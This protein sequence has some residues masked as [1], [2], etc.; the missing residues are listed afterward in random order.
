[1][2]S[3][4]RKSFVAVSWI[5]PTNTVPVAVY[6]VWLVDQWG[7]M[8][9][10][11]SFLH[12]SL[13]SNVNAINTMYQNHLVYL[14]KYQDISFVVTVFARLCNM[15]ILFVSSKRP[16]AFLVTNSRMMLRCLFWCLHSAP[17]VLLSTNTMASLFHEDV[18][19]WKHFPRYWPFVR[20]IHRSPLDFPHKVQWRWA[21]M[22]SLICAWTNVWANTLVIW[23]TIAFIMTPL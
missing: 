18:I 22:F 23:D 2:I 17:L 13:Q 14:A 8:S 15:Y 5:D 7:K 11:K 19:K 6:F 10:A 21:L 4:C 9:I 16:W 3:I 12:A 1:M 20:G